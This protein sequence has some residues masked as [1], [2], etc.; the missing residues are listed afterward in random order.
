MSFPFCSFVAA[1]ADGRF[2]QVMKREITII[3]RS[4]YACQVSLWGKSAENFAV[5][6]HSVIAFKDVRVGDFKG[7]LTFSY[8]FASV[9]DIPLHRFKQE[10]RSQ[11]PSRARSRST[12]TSWR[13]TPFEDGESSGDGDPLLFADFPL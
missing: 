1:C 12:R 9:A 2:L 6:Q 13:R 10:R 8:R 3:D 7:Q 11:Y 5:E 4:E